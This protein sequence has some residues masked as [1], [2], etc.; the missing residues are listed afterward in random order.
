MKRTGPIARRTPLRRGSGPRCS[1][2]KRRRRRARP[3]D[4]P[5]YLAWICAPACNAGA[6]SEAH[7]HNLRGAGIGRKAPDRNAMPLCTPHHVPGI[8][9]IAGPFGGWS[10][11]ELRAWQDQRVLALQARWAKRAQWP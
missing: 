8:H 3:T 7:H 9:A 6:P 5:A 1:P 4:D 2:M 11:D 10:K